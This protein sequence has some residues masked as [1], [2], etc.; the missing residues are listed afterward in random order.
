MKKALLALALT[1]SLVDVAAFAQQVDPNMPAMQH[2]AKP[3]ETQG[4]GIAVAGVLGLSR[5][6]LLDAEELAAID[7][8]GNPGT[9]I[10]PVLERRD[11]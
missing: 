1:D 10:Q 6:V 2:K 5:S 9:I 3:A 11:S 4:I 8:T 7:D